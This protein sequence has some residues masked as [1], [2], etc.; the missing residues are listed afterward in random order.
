MSLAIE[1]DFFNSY[2]VRKVRSQRSDVFFSQNGTWWPGATRRGAYTFSQEAQ[3]TDNWYIE[4][5]RIRGGFNNVSTDQ[6]VRAYLDDPFPLQQDRK[7]T[8]IYS[9]IYNSRTGVNDTNVFSV[10]T[11]ITKSL[12]PVNGSIQFTYAEDTNL[13]VFQENRIHRALIDKDTIYTT[14][15]GTQ[16]Q[17]G[18]AVIGQFVPY[19]GEYGISKNPESFAIYNY[20]K[21][22]ADRNRNAIMRLSNDGL[23]EISM[24]GMMDW[25][26]D[27]LSEMNLDSVATLQADLTSNMNTGDMIVSIEIEGDGLPQVGMLFAPPTSTAENVTIT[28]INETSANNYDIWLSK[29]IDVTLASGSVVNIR[30]S[31][32]SEIIGGWDIHNK[33]YVVSL[34]KYPNKVENYI[35]IPIEDQYDTVVFEE[36]IN[37]W[38][39][40]MTYKPNFM[41]SLLNKYYTTIKTELWQQHYDTVP[42]STFR[43]RFYSVDYGSDITFVFNQAPSTVKNFKTISY[44]GSSG[45]EVEAFKSG[46]E[47]FDSIDPNWVEF[48][49]SIKSI[50]SY[51]EGLYSDPVTGQPTRAGFNRKE[52]KYVAN[53][54][55]NSTPRPGEIRFGADMTGIK[56]YFATVKIKTDA[57]TD[58]GGPKELWSTGTEFVQSNGFQ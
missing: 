14:E 18:A 11:D 2:V 21:Y 7:A 26:R 29:P 30:I 20:R 1:V 37:G 50:K 56:G 24:Y 49:D 15:S 52:N 43:S 39:S 36:Q 13:I 44:E 10:G 54:V 3:I 40:F 9:G 12:D 58:P 22:F 28:Y 17:A 53:L 46:N 51:Y 41:F 6:G 25:F 33:N 19:K 55:S 47:G 34:Q 45:W 32:K 42:A 35:N 38:V 4:E 57:T 31:Y 16:T 23:T 5:S 48:K 27:N 8:L